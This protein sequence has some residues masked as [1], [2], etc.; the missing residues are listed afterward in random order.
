MLSIESGVVSK[1]KIKPC[2]SSFILSELG[3]IKLLSPKR[4]E[5]R[6]RESHAKTQIQPAMVSAQTQQGFPVA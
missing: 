5:E 3:S 4:E 6:V 2:H 1:N